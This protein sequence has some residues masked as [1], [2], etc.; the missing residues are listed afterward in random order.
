MSKAP[1]LT[2]EAFSLNATK[3]AKHMNDWKTF[4]IP[5]CMYI[6]RFLEQMSDAQATDGQGAM[7]GSSRALHP[8]IL[9]LHKFQF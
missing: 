8:V 3:W 1:I 2:K 7:M 5:T 9:P 4:L 6:Y